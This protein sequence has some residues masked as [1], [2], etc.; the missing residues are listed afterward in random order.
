[1]KAFDRKEPFALV[2]VLLISIEVAS[3]VAGHRKEIVNKS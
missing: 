2:C 3:K 1:M